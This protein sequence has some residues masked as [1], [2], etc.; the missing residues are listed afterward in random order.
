MRQED[1]LEINNLIKY[2]P[3]EKGFFKKVV[4]FVK[5]VNNVNLSIK[6]Q[7]I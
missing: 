2:F 3:I 6:L 1:I 5:A 4:G 7:F